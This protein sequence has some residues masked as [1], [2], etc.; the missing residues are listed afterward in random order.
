M[1]SYTQYKKLELPQLLDKYNIQIINKNNMAIDSEL[2]KLEIKNESQDNLLAT[3]EALNTEVLRAIAKE[4]AIEN[5]LDTAL[6]THNTSEISHSD[7]RLLISGLTTRLNAL[8]DSDDTTLDQ[9]SEV[10]AYIKNNKSLIDGIT[11]SKVSVSDII[12]D[13]TSSAT[14]KTLSAKQGMILKGLITDLTAIIENKV[15][16]VSGKGLSTND[17]TT[18]E[19]NK[20]SGIAAGAEVNVQPDWNEI[21]INSDAYIKNK[22]DFNNHIIGD[23]TIKIKQGGIEKGSFT[24][25][26][27]EDV[28]IELE[29]VVE[30]TDPKNYWHW[31]W[32]TSQII[33]GGYYK[34]RIGRGITENWMV[35]FLLSTYQ[36]YELNLYSISGYSYVDNHWYSPKATMIDS[37]KK[38]SETIRFG[39]DPDGVLWIAF[40]ASS[41]TGVS[42]DCINP[43]YNAYF[44]WN[45]MFEIRY[46]Y[47]LT[48]T[49]QSQQ[50]VQ[51]PI[52]WNDA[53]YTAIADTIVTRDT[54]NHV[55]FNYINSNTPIENTSIG[56]FIVQNNNADGYYRKCSLASVKS[57]LGIDDLKNSVSNGKAL[58]AAAITEKGIPTAADASFATM[59]ANIGMISTGVHIIGVARGNQSVYFNNPANFTV[60]FTI[61]DSYW[62][63]HSRAYVL[64]SIWLIGSKYQVSSVSLSGD[65]VDSFPR[66][67][68]VEY[69]VASS[70]TGS[71][72]LAKKNSYS[73]TLIT[74]SEGS[75]TYNHYG[76]V[77]MTIEYGVM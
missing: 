45:K 16:K 59:A 44:D 12:D 66:S 67:A 56:S 39:Y 15:D 11:T 69:S 30:S 50:T 49:E 7:M 63:G 37:T 38:A 76:N 28:V 73:V 74:P 10:V 18:A 36:L 71:Y 1:A 24:T 70:A 2:H 72:S 57:Q 32:N 26:Q 48:G 51:P 58:A 22:P 3:K 21:D 29:K 14:D 27:S 75:A 61:S 55:Y 13:L 64:V 47:T 4:N 40:A 5:T 8:A 52:K 62:T 9:L 60:N 43:T 34:I 53:A 65:I 33:D 17:Y 42:I 25:N 20:L 31:H 23:A 35:S 77:C 41:Y 68:R 54:N 46:E 6:S 19:K